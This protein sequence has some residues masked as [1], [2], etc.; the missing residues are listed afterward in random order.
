M[1]RLDAGS[2]ECFVFTFKE[3]L[4]SA[5]AHDVKIRV[6]SFHIE[7][8]EEA[9][10]VEATFDAASL[11]VVS[12]MSGGSESR[13]SLSPEQKREIEGNI[14]G[15]VLDSDRHP[16]IHFRSTAVE[17]RGD[18]FRIRG[19]LSLHGKSRSMV[20][21][22]TRE[23]DRYVAKARI[24]QPDFGIRPYSALFGTLKV[25]ADVTV[26]VLVPWPRHDR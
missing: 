3:G 1:H 9:R 12:A 21:E 2:A 6:K 23:G 7:V 8:H 11:E 14:R 18:G 15:D 25:K 16:E 20:V 26:E 19:E 17:E 22:L 10:R 4:L 13:G 24:H 5:V